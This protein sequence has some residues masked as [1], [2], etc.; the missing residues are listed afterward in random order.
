MKGK[1]RIYRPTN[2]K[3]WMLAYYVGPLDGR[4]RIRESARTDDEEIARKRLAL[5]IRQAANAQD[6]ISD[7]E[8]PTHRRVTVDTLFDEL[9]ADYERREIK[10]LS[11][12]R[13]RLL[14][15]KPLRAVFG[16]RR[17]SSVTTAEVTRY[18]NDRKAAGFANATVNREMELLRRAL[19][20]GV[21]SKSIVRMPVFPQRFAE[22]NARQGFFETGDFNKILAHLPE[23]LDDM[24]RFAFATGWRRGMLLEMRWSHVDRAGRLVKL[25]DSKNDDPQSIPLDDELLEVIER[26]WQGRQYRTREGAVGVSEFVFHRDGKA[27]PKA[28]FNKQFAVARKKAGVAGRIFHDLRR[29]AARNMI[30]GG[31]PQSVAMRV[32]GHRSSSMF[33]RY[34]VSSTDD[35][36]DA[37]R[38]AREYAATRAA[39]GE[40][41]TAFPTD[42]STLQPHVAANAMIPEGNW[43]GGR[44]S[45]PD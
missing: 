43:L 26:R 5:R 29:T 15:G 44:E 37:L 40:N 31:V 41:V 2:R 21:A 28:T 24:A 35:K 34:D 33:Q 25:P 19:R 39:V 20:L 22:R 17:A 10:S 32:T 12:V 16:P 3:I 27:I 38:R 8:E 7:F 13:L 36:L 30:R 11:H 6:G 45:N 18:M 1:G 42:L 14:P 9:L 4:R 23:P